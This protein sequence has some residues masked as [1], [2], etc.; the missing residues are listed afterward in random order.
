[1]NNKFLKRIVTFFLSIF[2]SF[3][4]SCSFNINVSTPNWNGEIGQDVI[5]AGEISGDKINETIINQIISEEVYLK[6]VVVVENKISELLIQDEKIEEI[7]LCKNIYVPQKNILDFSKHGQVDSMF[8][9]GIELGPLL[10]KISIGTGVILTLTVL[11]ISGL[12]GPVASVVAAAAPAALKGAATGTLIGAFTGAAIGGAD[13]IDESGRTSAIIGFSVAVVGLV[14]ATISAILAIPSGGSTTASAIFGV[15]VALAGISLIS[16]ALTGYNMVKTLT[17]TDV[18]DI[19]WNNVDWNK[20]GV[21]AAE[22]AINYGADGYMWG[23]I[24][25]AVLGGLSGYEYY[26]KHGTPYSNYNARINQTPKNGNGG[27]WT[28]KRGESSF[29]LDEP[30]ACKNG[31]IVSEIPYKNGVPDFSKHALRQVAIDNMTNNRSSNF[32]QADEVLAKN[33]SKIKFNGKTWS[34]RDVSNYRINNGLTWHEM[35]NMQT[36][37]L[38]PTEINATW[39]HLGGVGE[40]NVMIGTQG[41]DYFD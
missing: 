8:G 11:S 5:S 38:V 16:T 10:T 15:K 30:I 36:M 6:E 22:K 13:V 27:H 40:Y 24:I 1:M 33:W 4:S 12:Q 31:D 20:V 7:I 37:Q 35:N 23:S 25:G 41:G 21:S 39:G 34:A 32:R 17:T 3:V 2:V 29:V 26:E 19:N 14:M 28:G 9:D 18:H